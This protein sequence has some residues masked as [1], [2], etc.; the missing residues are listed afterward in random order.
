MKIK[1]E[2]P[3]YCVSRVSIYYIL[4]ESLTPYKLNE[5]FFCPPSWSF[6]GGV[7]AVHMAAA[8]SWAGPW[9]ERMLSTRPLRKRLREADSYVLTRWPYILELREDGLMELDVKLFQ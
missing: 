1:V 3:T 5:T 6:S 2:S 4:A 9:A 8:H 7:S